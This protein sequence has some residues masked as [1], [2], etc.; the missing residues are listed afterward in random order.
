MRRLVH[1]NH[2]V[3]WISILGHGAGNE[4]EIERKRQPFR[5]KPRSSNVR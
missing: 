2:D 1:Q 4:S 5:R 3:Q